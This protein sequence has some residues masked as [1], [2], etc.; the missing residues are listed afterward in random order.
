MKATKR[1]DAIER[2]PAGYHTLFD[3]AV[4]LFH[5]DERVRAVWLSGSA[6]R[7]TIDAASDLDLLI[8]VADDAHAEFAASWRQWLEHITPTVLAEEQWFAKGSFWSITPGFERFDVVVEPASQVPHTL[9]ATRTEVFDRDGL[10]ARL[11]P[12]RERGPDAATVAKLVEEWFH[13]SAMIETILWRDDW[14]LAA[15]HLHFL[16]DLLYKLY[17]ERNQPLPPMGIKRWSEKLTDAQ[18]TTLETL[19]TS[20]ASH[21]ELVNAH[22]VISRA[23][24]A[25]A[26][27]LAAQLRVAWPDALDDA[28]TAHLRDVLKL[29][30]PYPTG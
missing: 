21:D 18:R 4:E 3:R 9:F 27:P 8:A 7:G 22:L 17:V 15:E 10:T 30:D 16:R 1:H 6:A 19:P 23:F 29:E 20:A 2:L 13:F 24:L 28:A 5:G 11:P 14:L 26:K 25:D 12:E